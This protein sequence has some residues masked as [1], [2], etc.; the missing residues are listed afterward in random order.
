MV[1][2]LD[3]GGYLT[4]G[5]QPSAS[6]STDFVAAARACGMAAKLADHLDALR[7]ALVTGKIEVGPLLIRVPV[8]TMSPPTSLFP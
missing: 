5:G 7:D 4:T 3:N 1:I 2:I 6:S 8:G